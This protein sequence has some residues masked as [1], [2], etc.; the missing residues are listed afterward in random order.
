M[1]NMCVIDLGWTA[2]QLCSFLSTVITNEI[3]NISYITSQPTFL[4]SGL[5]KI[6][7]TC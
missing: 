4:T 1:D 2:G 5:R 3:I 6:S 7:S